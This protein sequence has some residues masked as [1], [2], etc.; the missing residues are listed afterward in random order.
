MNRYDQQMKKLVDPTCDNGKIKDDYDVTEED[1]QWTEKQLGTRLPADYRE[2]LQKYSW[3][4][5]QA[6]F[7]LSNGE[8]GS[9]GWFIG[10]D[11][12]DAE[13]DL[14]TKY[15]KS[16]DHRPAHLLEI[17]TDGMGAVFMSLRE[18]DKGSIYFFDY[19]NPIK[20]ITEETLAFAANSFDEFINLLVN[21]AC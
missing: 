20:D 3:A 9:V 18:N 2:F 5:V 8:F 1:L 19:G 12:P 17:A 21:S 10:V 4:G 15:K 6:A 13:G 7:P 16:L 14:V 11:W